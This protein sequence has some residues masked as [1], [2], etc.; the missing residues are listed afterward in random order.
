MWQVSTLGI[1]KYG[2]VWR[3][4]ESDVQIEKAAIRRGGRWI[5]KKGQQC[6]AGLYEHYLN[7]QKLYW[8]NKK[9]HR[10]NELLLRTFVENRIIGILG[11]ASSGKTREAS[12]YALTVYSIWPNETTVMVS[13]TEMRSLELRIWGETKKSWAAAKARFPDFPGC[14]IGSRLMITT[15]AKDDLVRDFRN[16]IVGIPCVSGGNFVGISKYVGLKNTRVILV[17]DEAQFL[18]RGFLD[19]ISNLNKNAGFQCIGLGNPKDRT[20]ALGLICEPADSIGGWDGRDQTEKTTTWPTR[21]EGGVAVQLVGTDSP[22]FDVPEDAPVPFPFLITRKAIASD[23]QFYGRESLQFTMMNLGMMPADSTSR[24]V[25]TRSLCQ[26]FHAMD[27]VIWGSTTP[28]KLAGLDAAY[29]STGGDRCILTFLSMAYDSRGVQT[30]AFEE[31]PMVVPVSS[32]LGLSPEDQIAEFVMKAC[33]TRSMGP[34]DVFYDSTG[35]GTLGT[36]FARLWSPHVNPVEFGGKPSSRPVSLDIRK[37]CKD[38]YSKF[39][40]ELWYSVRYAIESG[41]IRGLPE[42]VMLEGCMREWTIVAGNKIEVESKDKTKLRMGRSPDLFDSF[43][44]AVEGARR[45]GFQI[46]RLAGLSRQNNENWLNQLRDKQRL[47]RKAKE[48]NYA[49]S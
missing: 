9:W 11:P 41:Q 43:V 13:S 32:K 22:N 5:G 17:A 2:A 15:D 23:I 24:R 44:V 18:P 35:R 42:A 20:D 14:A 1:E 3:K 25:I 31:P 28:K 45:R 40:T 19:S 7:L 30:L 34:E 8:P 10:W 33:I 46:Q 39:V 48:L 36:A 37:L 26:Q 21:F 38:Y 6:G 29:G 49:A 12:D 27:E 4:G 16:G 47:I